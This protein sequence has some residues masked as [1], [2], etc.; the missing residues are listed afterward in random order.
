M[1]VLHRTLAQETVIALLTNR[2]YFGRDVEGI[3]TLRRVVHAGVASAL[4][5]QL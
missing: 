5:R 1:A 2:V 3:Q 4:E